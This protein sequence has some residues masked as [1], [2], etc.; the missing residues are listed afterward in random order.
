MTI[1]SQG[2]CTDRLNLNSKPASW[3]WLRCLVGLSGTLPPFQEGPAI[4]L[5]PTIDFLNDLLGAFTPDVSKTANHTEMSR[6][7]SPTSICA[8]T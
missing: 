6:E 4:C 2:P 3:Y 7:Y 1:L 5:N 8:I